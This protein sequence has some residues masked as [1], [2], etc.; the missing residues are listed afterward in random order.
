[1][2]RKRRLEVSQQAAKDAFVLEATGMAE[3]LHE[4]CSNFCKEEEIEW[5]LAGKMKCKKV[6]ASQA[7]HS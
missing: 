7:R 6:S 2:T 3:S 1:M 4:A 5:I